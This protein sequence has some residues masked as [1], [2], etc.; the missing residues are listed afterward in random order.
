M[1]APA[2]DGTPEG[3]AAAA[4]ARE[5]LKQKKRSL[6]VRPAVVW[7][8]LARAASRDVW[9]QGRRTVALAPACFVPSLPF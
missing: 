3:L 4:A 2:L 6:E 1:S 8:Q 7:A 5:A 9:E